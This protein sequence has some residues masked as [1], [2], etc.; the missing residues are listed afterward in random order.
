M[1][2][3]DDNAEAIVLDGEIINSWNIYKIVDGEIDNINNEYSTEELLS[4]Y[5]N[6]DSDIPDF[7]AQMK[8]MDFA[9]VYFEIKEA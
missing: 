8:T 1:Y 7:E 9:G 3:A 6:E 4:I 2:N 5:N